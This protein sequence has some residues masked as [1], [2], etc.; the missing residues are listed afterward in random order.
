MKYAKLVI[1]FLVLITG[2]KL[3]SQT[4]EFPKPMY[5]RSR[6]GLHQRETPSLSGKKTGIFLF[7]HR[8]II[9]E[10]GP[11]AVIDGIDDYWYR[12]WDH[13]G[14]WV[15]GGYL[16]EELPLD[17]LVILGEWHTDINDFVYTFDPNHRYG[18]GQYYEGGSI[19]EGTWELNFNIITIKKKERNERE[20]KTETFL[21]IVN[22]RNNIILEYPNNEQIEFKRN[23]DRW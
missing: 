2:N 11:R 13:S 12:S 4:A 16:S 9:Y 19:W 23:N 14:C 18:E 7:G 21:L 10:R 8:I 1:I 22:N 17:A 20:Y 15:F 6:E 5:V 3:F